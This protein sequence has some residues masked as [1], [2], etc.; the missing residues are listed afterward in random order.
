MIKTV[1]KYSGEQQSKQARYAERKQLE[2]NSIVIPP[3]VD[4]QRRRA[5]LMVVAMVW[6]SFLIGYAMGAES[7]RREALVY[8][9]AM[10]FVNPETGEMRFEWR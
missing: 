5:L 9:S 2:R 7:V 1:T 10:E 6:I 8:G 3:P 4:L